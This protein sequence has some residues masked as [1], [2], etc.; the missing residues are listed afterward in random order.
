MKKIFVNLCLKKFEFFCFL[1][2]FCIMS[3]VEDKKGSRGV[4][5]EE[6]TFS[7]LN[8]GDIIWAR[9]YTNEEEKNKLEPGHFESPFIIIKKT[10]Q[11]LYGVLCTSKAHKDCR[12]KHWYYPLGRFT[13]HLSKNTFVSLRSIGILEDKQ[14]I[15]KYLM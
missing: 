10:K 12:I 13:S 14:F 7:S 11:K 8:V 5:V 15:R 2:E 1:L 3:M 4:Q 9:R 6:N